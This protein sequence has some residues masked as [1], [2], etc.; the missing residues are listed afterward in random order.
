MPN[1]SGNM[2]MSINRM[3]RVATTHVSSPTKPPVK[4]LAVFSSLYM[5]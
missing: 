5:S 4:P 3:I 2:G 1:Y